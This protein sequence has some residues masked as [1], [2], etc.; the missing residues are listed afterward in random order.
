MTPTVIPLDDPALI[1]LLQ[2]KAKD[3][4]DEDGTFR[5]TSLREYGWIAVPMESAVHFDQEDAARLASAIEGVAVGL[6][7]V[8]IE[9]L[10]NVEAAYHVPATPEG[11]LGFSA[12][13][14]LFTYL[15]LPVDAQFAILCSVADY[16]LIAGRRA[17]VEKACGSEIPAAFDT[18]EHFANDRALPVE[19]QA[20]L[21]RLLSIYRTSS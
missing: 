19:K 20:S 7:A 16:Y 6:Y 15:L 5:P 12:E 3:L 2:R 8:A 1:S 14:G 18:F 11:L 17:F 9:D 13:C 4:V 10:H 21:K